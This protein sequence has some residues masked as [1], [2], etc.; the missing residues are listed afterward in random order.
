M[1]TCAD[2]GLTR[3]EFLTLSLAAMQASASEIGL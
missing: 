1:D 2:I 3:E